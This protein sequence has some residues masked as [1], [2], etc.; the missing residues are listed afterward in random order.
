LQAPRNSQSL[1]TALFS[2]FCSHSP[3]ASSTMVKVSRAWILCTVPKSV[4]HSSLLQKFPH[5]FSK[6]FLDTMS[7]PPTQ[8]AQHNKSFLDLLPA[9]VWM[10]PP[11]PMLKF[12][13][14]ATVLRCVTCLLTVSHGGI[15]L[16][17]RLRPLSQKCVSYKRGSL[18]FFFSLS[19]SPCDVFCQEG[20]HQMLVTW[21]WT[22]QSLEL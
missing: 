2:P 19:L 12:N 17:N 10:Y 8:N 14:I 3:L 13:A 21:Y 7:T 9:V 16:M 6:Y 20:F 11:K 18:T 5:S 15:S 1:R 22:S 4:S